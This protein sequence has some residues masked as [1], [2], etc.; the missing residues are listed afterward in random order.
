MRD[1]SKLALLGVFLVGIFAVILYLCGET[2][3]TGP[4]VNTDK[5]VT[6]TADAPNEYFARSESVRVSQFAEEPLSTEAEADIQRYRKYQE[7]CLRWSKKITEADNKLYREHPLI[8]FARTWGRAQYREV[9]GKYP[10]WVDM[11]LELRNDP[12]TGKKLAAA[13]E[14]VK[15]LLQPVTFF[16]SLNA[17]D[18]IGDSTLGELT[19]SILADTDEFFERYLETFAKAMESAGIPANEI[20]QVRAST[21]PEEVRLLAQQYGPQI[22]LKFNSQLAALIPDRKMQMMMT[23]HCR[24]AVLD[25]IATQLYE[26]VW[27]R[28]NRELRDRMEVE[29]RGMMDLWEK[30][31]PNSPERSAMASIAQEMASFALEESTK[32]SQQDKTPAATGQSK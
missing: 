18:P 29:T 25:R 7:I 17:A 14:L 16:E 12:A 11:Y 9:V 23:A 10:E 3:S 24:A 27:D 2:A 15:T 31:S 6:K 32:T 4:G 22:M 28:E 8:G 30:Y 1:R 19:L 5:A 21:T 13:D 20:A 26:R